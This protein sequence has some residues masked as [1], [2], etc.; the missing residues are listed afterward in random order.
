MQFFLVLNSDSLCFCFDYESVN[1]KKFDV[2]YLKTHITA[3]DRLCS[4][5]DKEILKPAS[6][7]YVKKTRMQKKHV[8]SHNLTALLKGKLP[9]LLKIPQS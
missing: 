5:N 8:S 2:Q 9:M 6:A 7:I 3:K 4:T 1:N